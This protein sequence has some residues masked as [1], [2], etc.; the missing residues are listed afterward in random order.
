M[1]PIY[2]NQR[3]IIIS[4]PTKSPQA[5]LHRSALYAACRNLTPTALKLWLYFADNQNGTEFYISPKEI[6]QTTGIKKGAYH[7]A[8]GQLVS[9][10]YITYITKSSI[11]FSQF[12]KEEM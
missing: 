1:K 5:K 9:K 6:E 7:R 4:K 2:P 8:F 11:K 12:A 10:G 3:K